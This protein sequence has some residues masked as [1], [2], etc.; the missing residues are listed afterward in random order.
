[1]ITAVHAMV[2]AE[3]PEAARAFF[4]DVLG[5][6]HVDIGGG[7]LIFTGGPSEIGVHPSSWQGAD[8]PGGTRQR[9]DISLMCDDLDTTMAELKDRG[10]EF[11]TEVHEQSWGREVQL[12]VPGAG[13]ITLYQPSYDAP[14]TSA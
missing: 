12:E 8:G 7:W 4:R 2:Y 1:M 14:A 5:L 11:Q 6:S 3:D 13:P 9:F 10:A